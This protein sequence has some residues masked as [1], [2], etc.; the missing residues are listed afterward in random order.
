MIYF[1]NIKI[2]THW[3][4][5]IKS[6]SIKW[7]MSRWFVVW[8]FL[9]GCKIAGICVLK[10]DYTSEKNKFFESNF[11]FHLCTEQTLVW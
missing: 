11:W 7:Q 1:T 8:R 4:A 10:T 3:V 5:K 2:D 6:S 9:K